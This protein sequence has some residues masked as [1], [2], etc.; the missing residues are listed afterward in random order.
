MSD[1]RQETLTRLM[2]CGCVPPPPPPPFPSNVMPLSVFEDLVYRVAYCGGYAGTKT[3]VG[4]DLANCLN[5]STGMVGLI[6]QKGSVEDFP[7]IGQPNALYIDNERQQLYFW[8]EGEGYYRI[9][10][11][12][13]S[14]G[15]E[16]GTILYGGNATTS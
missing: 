11:E 4:E 3:E 12:G 16:P 9:K 2:G 5:N 15:L 1:A 10:G 7:D 8:K 13:G 6:I 14:G